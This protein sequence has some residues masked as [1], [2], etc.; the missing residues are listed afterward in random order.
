[1]DLEKLRADYGKLTLS[2]A[3]A[4]DDPLALLAAW[5]EEAVRAEALEPNAMVLATVDAHG[6]PSSRIVL[7]RGLGAGGLTFFTNYE[8]RKG[9]EMAGQARVAALFF[10]PALER[11]VRVEGSVDRAPRAVS[12][13][14]FASRP[15]ASRIA[16][17]ASP[18][19][20]P[21]EDRDVLEARVAEL[22]TMYP[23]GTEVPRPAHWGGY[24]LTPTRIE[25]WQGGSHRLHD[26]IEFARAAAGWSKR[27]L[28]P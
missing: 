25:F 26:R 7:L 1:M 19:S 21:L 12:D 28:A 4:G 14:Y 23:E 6:A 11:Q 16:A 5:L 10:W 24:V 2:E 13:A 15:H 20:Q 3:S 22:S 9:S 18:Q 17:M 8:S 27:R